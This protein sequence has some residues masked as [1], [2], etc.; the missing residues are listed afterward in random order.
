MK[1]ESKKIKDL[2]KVQIVVFGGF[3][4]SAITI[5]YTIIMWCIWEEPQ[6]GMKVTFDMFQGRTLEL[7]LVVF[8]ILPAASACIIFDGIAILWFIRKH[9]SK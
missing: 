8:E 6:Q 9:C 4:I 3:L 7:K 1:N 5:V 2:K